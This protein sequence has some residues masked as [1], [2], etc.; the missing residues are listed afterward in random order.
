MFCKEP[1][2]SQTFHQ[3]HQ[4]QWNFAVPIRPR[5][6]AAVKSVEIYSFSDTKDNKNVKIPIEDNACVSSSM[7][8][9]LCLSVSHSVR[10]RIKSIWLSSC[11]NWEKE[12]NGEDRRWVRMVGGLQKDKVLPNNAI[13]IWEFWSKEKKKAPYTRSRPL[14]VR[15]LSIQL[16][17]L[18]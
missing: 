13:S 4:L 1:K 6:V 2:K 5:S 3:C 7:L 12:F 9:E 15:P 14:L 11:R 18:T 8:K 17:H 10:L 16:F